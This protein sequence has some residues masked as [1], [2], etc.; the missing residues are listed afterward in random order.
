MFFT[1]VCGSNS[2]MYGVNLGPGVRAERGGVS[3][4]SQ[5]KNGGFFGPPALR[6]LVD[7]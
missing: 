1:G 5:S 4:E 7:P 3:I 2:I 6:F